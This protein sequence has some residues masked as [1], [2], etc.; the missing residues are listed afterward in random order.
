MSRW[1]ANRSENLLYPPL[2]DLLNIGLK[3]ARDQGM[4]VYLFEGFR[5][6]ERQ[7][8]LYAKGR[9]ISGPIVTNARYGR[10]WHN[11]G[12]AVDLVF[13]GSPSRGIQW[14][15]EGDYI[16]DAISDYERLG[17]ILVSTGLDWYGDSKRFPEMPHF[18]LTLGMSINYAQRL[19]HEEGQLAIWREMDKRL[20]QKKV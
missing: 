9:T 7:E 6:K 17:P 2:K 4:K 19:L 3:K 20:A 12:L 15:W 16:K 10:S 13:D 5:D 8:W 14:S 18:Q 11:V 1:T